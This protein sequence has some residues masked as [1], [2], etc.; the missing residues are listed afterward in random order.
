MRAAQVE[1]P[2][3]PDGVV[4]RDVQL[5]PGQAGDVLVSVK[6][7]GLGF[8]DTLMARDRYQVR[9]PVPFV[10]GLEFSGVVTHA[11]P[12]SRWRV[13]DSVV[14]HSMG[15]ACAEQ[16]WSTPG[17]LAPLSTELDHEQ[18]AASVVNHHTAL[19]ALQRRAGLRSG[20]RVLVHGA[21]GGLGSAVAQIAVA[22]GAQVTA[23]AGTNA[24]R[25]LAY[26]AQ[27]HRVLTPENWFDVVRADG[28][29]DVIVDPVGGAVF[30]QS[31]RCLAPEG[32]LITVGFACGTIPHAAAN[33]L[34]LRN[35]AVVGAAWRELLALH[36][37]LFSQT[38]QQLAELVTAG[39]RPL[40]GSSY[41]LAEI[42]R[43]LAAIEGREHPGKVIL[44]IT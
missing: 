33:R 32:R 27:A 3:G 23:V 37:E 15:G 2:I 7:A 24:G 8:V 18:G 11:P 10:P 6:A 12:S 26:R 31:V 42:G 38:A 30:E 16:V 4:V 22:L 43:A 13:G 1:D 35:A 21:G 36:P 25:D 19:V 40:V 5:P 34:L 14:G 20:E 41:N 44:R 9:L 28:G 29:A 39:L 17:L